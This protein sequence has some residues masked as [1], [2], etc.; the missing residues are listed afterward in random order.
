MPPEQNGK[1]QIFSMEPIE[2]PLDYPISKNPEKDKMGEKQEEIERAGCEYEN[3]HQLLQDDGIDTVC[4][5]PF[6]SPEYGFGVNTALSERC[7][8]NFCF[9]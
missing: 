7:N 5:M 4:T 1:K 2:A 3:K 8:E 9:C 6:Y